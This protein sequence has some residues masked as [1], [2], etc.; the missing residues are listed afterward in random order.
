MHC[1][2]GKSGQERRLCGEM[3]HGEADDDF[4]LYDF[5]HIGRKE[6]VGIHAS[7]Y[8]LVVVE[9]VSGYMSMGPAAAR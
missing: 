3:A 6:C 2:G 1:M 4:V 5:L 7:P 8:F 9:D